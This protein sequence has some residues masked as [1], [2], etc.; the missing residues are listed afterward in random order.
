MKSM[1]REMTRPNLPQDLTSYDFFKAVAILLMVI[2]HIG[3]YFF[4]DTD[5]NPEYNYFRV[6]GRMCV[7]IWFFLIGYARSRDLGL[8]IIAGA[9]AL[10]IC[11][12]IIGRTV[13]PVNVLVSIIIV[14]LVIDYVM[15][16]AQRGE[17]WLWCI[18]A[19]LFV[20]MIPLSIFW[21]YG[22]LGILLAM[23]GYMVAHQGQDE[24]KQALTKKFMIFCI[25]VFALYQQPYFGFTNTQ[26]IIMAAGSGLAFY[27]LLSFE[28]K[29]YP[30]LT[31]AFPRP[32]TLFIQFCGR[33]TLGIYV[34]HLL[35]FKITA[36]MIGMDGYHLFQPDFFG[37]LGEVMSG[38]SASVSVS[39]SVPIEGDGHAY[40]E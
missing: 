23:F 12:V 2:D 39:V 5:S 10:V 26:F 19:V 3:F 1:A 7:P 32:L 36:L 15:Y 13:V 22:S 18:S 40:L 37:E 24:D 28:S 30:G 17:V 31:Q 27:V 16:Y 21:E 8:M 11:D 29:T 34:V 9:A 4:I 35:V 14:R 25:V 33:H 38:E 20:L 6:F